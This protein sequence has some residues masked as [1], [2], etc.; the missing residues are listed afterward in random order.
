MRLWSAQHLQRHRNDCRREGRKSV[1]TEIL[2]IAGQLHIWAHN[3]YDNMNIT[4]T[5]SSQ[6][7]LPEWRWGGGHK[8]K[9][10]NFLLTEELLVIDNCS[11]RESQFSLRVWSLLQWR[12]TQNG[13]M[14]YLYTVW[15]Y[16]CCD[17][18]NKNS[19]Q[20]IAKQEL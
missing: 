20:P 6:R 7:K 16:I 10:L 13:L 9:L 11:E 18:C 1:Q 15:G 19:E 17:W 8:G 2:D 5:T 12:I 4:S 14:W 3:G